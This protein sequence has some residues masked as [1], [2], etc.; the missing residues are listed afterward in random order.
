M[1]VGIANRAVALAAIV[2]LSFPCSSFA[3]VVYGAKILKVYTQSYE[4]STAH[5]VKVD[6]TLPTACSSNRVYID[7]ADK[8]LFATALASKLADSTIDLIFDANAVPKSAYAHA[9]IPCRLLS[10][11]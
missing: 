5:L 7:F 2:S 11:F 6:K 8:D 10:I 3:D 1:R 9:T 4:G